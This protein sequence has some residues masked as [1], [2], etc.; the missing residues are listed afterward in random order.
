MVMQFISRDNHP[1]DLHQ[2][3]IDFQS[4]TGQESSRSPIPAE[5]PATVPTKK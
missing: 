1:C 3:Q 5:A 2:A 4:L